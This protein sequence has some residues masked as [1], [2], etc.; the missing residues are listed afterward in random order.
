MI[1]IDEVVYFDAVT[2]TPSTSAAVDA[3]SAPTFEVMEEDTD[4]AIVSGTMT[5][6]TSKTGNYRGSITCSTA[7]GFEAGKWYSV[8]ATGIVGGVTGKAVVKNFRVAPAEA[9]AGVPKVD[10]WY[11]LGTLFTE[12]AA[13]RLVAGIVKF[14]NINSPQA[15]MDH[16]ILVDTVTTL[17]NAPADSSGITT[18]L[19]KFTG[20]TLLAQWLGLIAGKQT[21]N[22][23][24]RTE[25]RATGAGSG[26]FDETTDSM[27]AVRDNM[28]TAQTGDNFARL[29]APA[30]ASV[31]AD[32]AAV[33]LQTGAIEADTQDIQSRLPAA[34]TGAG[35]IKA[36]AQVVSDKTNYALTSA[37]DPAKTA[38]QAGDIPS[39]AANASA[40]AAAITSDHGVGSYVRNTEPLDADGVRSAVGLAANNLDTQFG[41]V[42]TAANLATAKTAID[43]IKLKTDNLPSVQIVHTAGKLWVLDAD[44]NP[45]ATAVGISG[46][47]AAAGAREIIP[48]LTQD[49]ALR[50]GAATAAGKT[51]GP[52]VGEAG[53]FEMTD[54]GSD[55]VL[56][57]GTL[58]ANSDRT[59]V[60]VNP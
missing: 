38:A 53:D 18:L 49:L 56:V 44:G 21:G 15:T 10:L 41:L 30:G 54:V 46:L 60:T 5:K 19:G 8:V 26:T 59:A 24:A 22:T 45:L 35:N 13:G 7:N 48:G 1:P 33:K 3:D 39:A 40:A 6:R 28:G 16:G 31:S 2:S 29:G 50:L 51:T 55:D 14:F 52:A 57:E 47:P 34:L 36:D 12:G 42:A 4:T 23:T 37:Y 9:V 20:I 58:N 43:A 11:G 27:E 32:V 17:T 25:L